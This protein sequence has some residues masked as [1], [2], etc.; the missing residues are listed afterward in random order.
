M[1][2]TALLIFRQHGDAVGGWTGLLVPL[3]VLLQLPQVA[4]LAIGF[5]ALN[6]HFKDIRDILSNLLTLLFFMTPIL[7]T[8][9]T[10]EA[11][12]IPAFIYYVV[13]YN[14]LTPFTLSYQEILF[15]GRLPSLEIWLS[16]GLVS[17]ATWFAAPGS[18]S[19]STIRWW[20]RYELRHPH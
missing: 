1:V 6:A 20:K 17:L 12:P 5:A 8:L 9:R 18:L 15:Y 3:V 16:M 10:L 11:P 2:A 4:G 7:Y 13:A 14:P 19:A